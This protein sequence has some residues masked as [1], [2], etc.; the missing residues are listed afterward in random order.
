MYEMHT[1]MNVMNGMVETFIDEKFQLVTPKEIGLDDRSSYQLFINED[2][3]AVGKGNR[4]TLDYYGGFE[5]A[6]TWC[7]S[8][9]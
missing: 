2:Y 5:Y 4:R 9:C 8:R 7:A 3:I 6:H 1:I